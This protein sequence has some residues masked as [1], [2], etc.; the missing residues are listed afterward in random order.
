MVICFQ[1]VILKKHTFS[2][3]DIRDSG[4]LVDQA[5]LYSNRN[6]M[7]PVYVK[8]GYNLNLDGAPSRELVTL[9]TPTKVAVLPEKIGF[10]RPRLSVSIGDSVKVGSVLFSDKRH[11]D[12]V[13]P[14][15]G[16]GTVADVNFGPR[17]VIR[18]IV[19]ELAPDEAYESFGAMD[20]KA[21]SGMD[22]ETLTAKLLSMG[23][24]PRI[25]TLPFRSIA[26]MN[27]MPPKIVVTLD[28]LEPFLPDPD[29][30]LTGRENFFA[31]G[32]KALGRL[33]E[34]VVVAASAR[35]DAMD[36]ALSE[37]LEKTRLQT[38][39]GA[40]PALDPGVVVYQTKTGAGE[41]RSWFL[42]GQDVVTLGELL[43]SGKYPVH[44]I[45]AVGGSMARSRRHVKTRIGVPLSD[46][47]ENAGL[48]EGDCRYVVGGLLT[49]FK[50]GPEGFMGFYEDA[51]N[52]IPEGAHREFLSLFRPGY[53][54]PSYSRTFLS[55]LNRGTMAAD[56]N[57][58]GE[59]RACIG[60]NHCPPV[61]PV[62]I[63]PQLAYKCILADDVDGALAHGLLDCVECGL[64][65]YV[66]PAK[67]DLVGALKKARR[68]YWEEQQ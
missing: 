15:P 35:K 2:G 55:V 17:R 24:W 11:P 50:S 20:E 54:K 28:G 34:K 51:L 66:C 31:F 19:I 53:R 22:R 13:F 10:I 58:H 8:H 56:T 37:V 29:V 27:E 33:S 16:A 47:A 30:Y 41:N 44:R 6:E 65:S 59:L 48:Q 60:C 12:L 45:M 62:E 26:P 7:K 21:L 25:R 49:G 14:S 63:L 32:L 39:S 52:L 38:V 3:A 4:M 23:F 43:L 57:A 18:S 67:I 42:G 5:A 68:T 46:L 36:P 64:C 61:C 40:Y 1:H 9:D